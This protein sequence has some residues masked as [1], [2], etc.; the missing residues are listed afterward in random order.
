MARRKT[1]A[2]AQAATANAS[3]AAERPTSWDLPDAPLERTP[4]EDALVAAHKAATGDRT[5]RALTV[6]KSATGA[7]AIEPDTADLK[8][9]FA[10]LA[11]TFG[12]GDIDGQ[13]HL[14]EQCG[15]V[16]W[17]GEP[18]TNVNAALALVR[19]IAPRNATEAMLAVQMV[20]VHNAAVEQLRRALLPEQPSEGVDR[21]T[22][23]ATRLL[24]LFTD[25]L[26][27]LDRLRGGGARQTVRVEHVH[28]EAGGQAIVGAVTLPTHAVS[29]GEVESA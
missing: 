12:G 22:H 26:A 2:R 25:Q 29:R 5:R 20:A 24:R 14:L 11:A 21:T 23:R 8:L 7:G 6:R 13:L 10:R 27:T 1:T 4:T 17:R 3:A 9:W 15:A 28:V 18:H 19:D 16:F